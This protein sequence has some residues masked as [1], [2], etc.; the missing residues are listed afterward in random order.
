MSILNPRQILA[1]Q[2]MGDCLIPGGSGFPK[3]SQSNAVTNCDRV[4]G[5]MPKKDL[6]DLKMLLTVFSFFPKPLLQIFFWK[7]EFL[8][9]YN[10]P[11]P[12]VIR[13]I[14]IGIRGLIM[15]LYYATDV[16]HRTIEYEVSVY[17][18]D[19]TKSESV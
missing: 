9:T 18:K 5:F 10:L 19:L 13:L 2:K 12:G 11:M 6:E 3:F 1:V 14:R 4:L 15:S 7:L 17:Q 8:W 16:A